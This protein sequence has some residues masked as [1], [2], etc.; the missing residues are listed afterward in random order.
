MTDFADAMNAVAGVVLAAQRW[1]A[2][3]P[4]TG[5]RVH[6]ELEQA[7]DR[8]AQVERLRGMPSFPSA[9]GERL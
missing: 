1:R 6:Y 7:V 4:D 2:E 9:S 8:L 3:E 5:S